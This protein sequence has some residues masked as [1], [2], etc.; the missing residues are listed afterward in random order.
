MKKTTIG[1]CP[2]CLQS[3]STPNRAPLFFEEISN[4]IYILI[5]IEYVPPFLRRYLFQ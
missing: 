1:L 3:L 5:G 4:P 2:I